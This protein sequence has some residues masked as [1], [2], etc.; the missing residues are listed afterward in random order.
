MTTIVTII[1]IITQ[2]FSR[3]IGFVAMASTTKRQH[4]R[5]QMVENDLINPADTY[6]P[7]IDR[8][9]L[10]AATA[11]KRDAANQDTT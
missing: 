4:D 5:H 1:I 7:A 11:T 6:H 3:C 2:R 8:W 9:H 10:T